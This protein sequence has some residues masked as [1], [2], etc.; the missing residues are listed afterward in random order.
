MELTWMIILFI[1]PM[2]YRTCWKLIKTRKSM[3]VREMLLDGNRVK[4]FKGVMLDHWGDI[5]K[6]NTIRILGTV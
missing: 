5:I 2:T 3:V 6:E 1:V 4:K